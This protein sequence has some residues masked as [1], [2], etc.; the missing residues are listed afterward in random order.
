MISY[1][2][3]RAVVGPQIAPPSP[4]VGLADQEMRMIGDFDV[5]S[6]ALWTLYINEARSYDEA[7]ILNLKDDMDGVL[8]FVRTYSTTHITDFD[9]CCRGHIPTGRFIFRCSHLVHNRQQAE[10]EYKPRR[11]NG[12]LPATKRRNART[13]FPA[14]IFNHSPNC[15]PFLSASALP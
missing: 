1:Q 9:M 14:N 3:R 6:N 5:G 12:I 13:D 7:H 11:P 8:I 10:F 2:H 15:H 4:R